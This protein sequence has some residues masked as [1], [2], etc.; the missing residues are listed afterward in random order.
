MQSTVGIQNKGELLYREELAVEK[1]QSSQLT[2][3]NSYGRIAD[4]EM[5][6]QGEN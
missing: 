2:P 5:G 1:G 6:Q 4:L 3:S